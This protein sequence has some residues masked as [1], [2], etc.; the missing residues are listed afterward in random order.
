MSRVGSVAFVTVVFLSVV[1]GVVW[2]RGAFAQA[3]TDQSPGGPPAARRGAVSVTVVNTMF[4]HGGYEAAG[5]TTLSD[6]F[7]MEQIGRAHV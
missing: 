7:S 3:W 2:E 6:T 5:G 4:V 1:C